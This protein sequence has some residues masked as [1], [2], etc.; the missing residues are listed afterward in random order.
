M[1]GK[2]KK[3]KKSLNETFNQSIHT[4]AQKSITI[5]HNKKTKGQIGCSVLA[6]PMFKKVRYFG[7][8]T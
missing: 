2:A 3:K 1:G 4:H 6:P 5:Q 8:L 7:E